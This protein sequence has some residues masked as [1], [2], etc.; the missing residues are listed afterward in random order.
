VGCV[1]PLGVPEPIPGR[2]W[3]VSE[4]QN[5]SPFVEVKSTLYKTQS[6]RRQLWGISQ[7]HNENTSEN[8]SF[9]RDLLCLHEAM[10]FRW[11]IWK[12]S[13]WD[14][15]IHDNNKGPTPPWRKAGEPANGAG[16]VVGRDGIESWGLF[17]KMHLLQFWKQQNFLIS[18]FRGRN[19]TAASDLSIS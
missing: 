14:G 7:F 6:N 15:F 13:C 18:V 9:L 2:S 5:H 1:R 11:A 4:C 3:S 19:S 12:Q 8:T 10:L 16:W 17:K